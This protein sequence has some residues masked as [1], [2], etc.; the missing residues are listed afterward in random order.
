MKRLVTLSVPSIP[1]QYDVL[2]PDTIFVRDL[3]PLLRKAIDELSHHGYVSSGQE[4]LCSKEKDEL[5]QED[6]P[7]RAYGIENGDHLLLF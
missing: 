6:L 2:I 3:I 7:L 5:L 1:A 4:L